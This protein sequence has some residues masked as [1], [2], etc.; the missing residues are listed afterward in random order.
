MKV[1]GMLVKGMTQLPCGKVASLA[2]PR[3]VREGKQKEKCTKIEVT[4][5]DGYCDR[6]TRKEYKTGC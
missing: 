1:P 3:E 6:G 4:K 5:S 2:P